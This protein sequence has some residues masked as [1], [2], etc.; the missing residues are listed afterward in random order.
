M[1]MAA[2]NETPSSGTIRE[3]WIDRKLF[4]VLNTEGDEACSKAAKDFDELRPI[5]AN[6]YMISRT[7]DPHRWP[8]LY[9]CGNRLP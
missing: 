8:Y 3:T 1:P 4:D 5:D 2:L 7:V 6:D 9:A